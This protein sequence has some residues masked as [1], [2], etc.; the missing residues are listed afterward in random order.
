[1]QTTL[2]RIGV[3]LCLHCPTSRMLQN[4]SKPPQCVKNGELVVLLGGFTR[5]CRTRAVQHCSR[6][7][8][9]VRA[10]HAPLQGCSPAGRAPISA[11]I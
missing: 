5:R 9:A 1:M 6:A 7:D 10:L 3:F 11:H 2:G 8:G 4:P